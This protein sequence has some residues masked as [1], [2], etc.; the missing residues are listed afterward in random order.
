MSK[1]SLSEMTEV[2]RKSLK[3]S[4]MQD[5]SDEDLSM[6]L[7]T[8]S[9]LNPDLDADD[10]RLETN[11]MGHIY[12]TRDQALMIYKG[13]SDRRKDLIDNDWADYS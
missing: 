11:E 13:M 12:I 4:D 7:V 6:I 10:V 3:I 1:K 5:F 9:Y 8:D 2:E